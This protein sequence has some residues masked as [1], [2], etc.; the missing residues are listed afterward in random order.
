[1]A[2]QRAVRE[3]LSSDLDLLAGA[4]LRQLVLVDV[5]LDPHGAEIGHREEGVAGIDILALGDLAVDD[6]AGSGSVEGDVRYAGGFRFID[7]LFADAPE[8]KFA[9][10]GGDQRVGLSAG[11]WIVR[12]AEPVAGFL[13]EAIVAECG[14][15]F[16]A[17]EIGDRLAAADGLAGVLDV[18]LVDPAADAGAD[19]S[20]LS[21]RLFDAAEGSDV[22]LER[23][24]AD[25][26]NLHTGG[27]DLGGGE[28]E[29]GAGL[30]ALVVYS[31][32]AR[33]SHRL[34]R[35][36][37]RPFRGK[38]PGAGVSQQ[39]GKDCGGD[40]AAAGANSHELLFVGSHLVVLSGVESVVGLAGIG[41][42]MLRSSCAPL[43]SAA[44]SAW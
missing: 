19:G 28:R 3:G 41:I 43:A 42:P 2:V 26:G 7:L 44:A 20:Q 40:Y 8:F 37:V 38:G 4:D 33:G 12:L 14:S 17:V 35:W 32:S 15:D 11:A 18:E 10:A 27:S 6:A 30:R 5:G 34:H 25:F 24:G 39:A 22:G 1:M 21:F 29:R 13:R 16:G 31:G 36:S 9:L 23:H